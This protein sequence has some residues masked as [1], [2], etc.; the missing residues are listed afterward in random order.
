MLRLTNVI[1]QADDV[2]SFNVVLVMRARGGEG[3]APY[4]SPIEFGM[5]FRSGPMGMTA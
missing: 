5:P 4:G 1:G 3:C 2:Q